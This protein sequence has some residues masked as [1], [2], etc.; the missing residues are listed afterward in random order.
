MADGTWETFAHGVIDAFR[1]REESQPV[2]Y[3]YAMDRALQ[4]EPVNE[5]RFNE[6]L[7]AY[8]EWLAKNHPSEVAQADLE[9]LF[10]NFDPFARCFLLYVIVGL[11]AVSAWLALPLLGRPWM[12]ALNRSAFWLGLLTLAVHSFGIVIRMY[13]QGVQADT[14]FRAPVTNLYSSAIFIGWCGVIL[15]LVI[16]R[17]FRIGIG[18][19]IVGAVGYLTSITAYH[20][21]ENQLSTTYQLHGG[22]TMEMMQAVLDTN[23]WLWTH[24]TC[25]TF[26]YAATFVAGLVGIVFIVLGLFTRLLTRD[27][28]KALGQ[29]IYGIVCF[30]VLLSFV[31]TVL[32][33]FWADKSWGRFWGWDPK[34]N[35]ALLIVLWNALILHA[36][37]CGWAKVRGLALLAIAGNMVTMW[38]WFGTN[39]LGVGLHAYG[40]NKTLADA[41]VWLWAGHVALI[42]IGLIPTSKW[43]SFGR[44]LPATAGKQ[45]RKAKVEDEERTSDLDERAKD[46][47]P[48][49]AIKPATSS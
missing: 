14:I 19:V 1:N 2:A 21:A 24:V 5:A 27:V 39:Q 11:L 20:L 26:G 32:G 43:R 38:S 44:D 47:P 34:E 8:Q 22:D 41:L 28:M 48:S 15:G 3:L 4:S 29:V 12:D 40:F 30:A 18:N 46:L 45:P 25:V 31:G 9:V 16:E 36:R 10:N 7:N 42:A 13:I 35:G 33:G 37:W 49:S 17:L 23:F 6:Q